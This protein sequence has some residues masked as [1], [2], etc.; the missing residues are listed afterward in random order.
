MF[1]EAILKFVSHLGDGEFEPE[2]LVD[3]EGR[4]LVQQSVFAIYA[5]LYYPFLTD[6]IK[7]SP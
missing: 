3:V 6:T 4:E 1:C 7:Y 2:L 5:A